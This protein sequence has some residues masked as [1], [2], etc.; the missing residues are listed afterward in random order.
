MTAGSPAFPDVRPFAELSRGPVASVFKAYDS[1]AGEVVLLKALRPAADPE[2]RARFADEARLAATV[3]HPNVVRVRRVALDGDAL[4]ADWVEGQDLGALL[5]AEG[6][7][8]PA[9]AAFVVAEAA[10]GLAAVHDAGILHRDVKPANVLVGA[11][12]SVRLTDFGLA[13]LADAHVTPGGAA[14]VR[15]T[16]GTLA[17]EIVRGDAAGPASDVFSLGAVLAHALSGQA[18]FAAATASGT[19]DAVLHVDAAASLSAD[20]RVPRALAAM[21]AAALDRSPLARPSAQAFADHLASLAGTVGPEDLAAFLDDPESTRRALAR[22]ATEEPDEPVEVGAA[23]PTSAAVEETTV[24]RPARSRVWWLAAA[25]GAGLVAVAA[26]RWPSP[27]PSRPAPTAAEPGP[28]P[29]RLAPRADSGSAVDRLVV[30]PED[31]TPSMAAQ[32]DARLAAEG[33]PS[34]DPRPNAADRSARAPAPAS[35]PAAGQPAPSRPS[36]PAGT[37]AEAPRGAPEPAA[38]SLTVA[39]EPW[40]SVL[41]D[42]RAAGTTPLGPVALAPGLHTVTLV[43]PGFPPYETPLRVAPGEAARVAVS[44]WQT[45]ARVTLDIAPW[46]VVWVDGQRWET[47]PPQTRPLTLAPGVHA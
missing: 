47:V 27:A 8:P 2:R 33:A 6:A 45:V 16:L 34:A 46:A 24:A 36:A 19:L 9:L 37:A 15:G 13:S 23:P 40:A 26:T 42:G 17:P 14:E 10:R 38:G 28:A 43:N 4:I 32:P 41:I 21:A 29:V 20:P 3:D 5:D 44:L 31:G 22:A 25:A 30:R 18:P 11:D 7:L 35:T 1:T 39:S 12:G